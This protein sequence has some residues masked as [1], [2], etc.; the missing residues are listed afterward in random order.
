MQSQ[1]VWR[2]GS[3]SDSRSE[4][5]EFESLCPH[6]AS[7]SKVCHCRKIDLMLTSLQ[8][9]GFAHPQH[10]N[11]SCLCICWYA[12][13][14]RTS[15]VLSSRCPWKYAN[16]SLI[17]AW[18]TSMME[19]QNTCQPGGADDKACCMARRLQDM[20]N[21]SPAP[22]MYLSVQQCRHSIL[23]IGFLRVRLLGEGAT[24]YPL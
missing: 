14:A 8:I 5:W 17:T 21:Q 6:F 2:D 4:G 23:A 10:R 19:S 13:D 3:A 12:C 11:S 16:A 15:S 9:A 1:G 24:E 7:V 22:C 20:R 18:W